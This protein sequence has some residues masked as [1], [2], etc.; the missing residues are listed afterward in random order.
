[1]LFSASNDLPKIIGFVIVFGDT[2]WFK[3]VR[4][5]KIVKLKF[6]N[7]PL[8]TRMKDASSSLFVA[9]VKKIPR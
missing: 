6:R 4:I 1:M 9:I 3:V 2:E 8:R 7:F 5:F